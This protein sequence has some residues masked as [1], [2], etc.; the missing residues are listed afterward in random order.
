MAGRFKVCLLHKNFMKYRLTI[1]NLLSGLL[2]I[3]TVIYTISNYSE[4][5]MGLMLMITFIIIAVAGLFV[6]FLLQALTR[7]LKPKKRL[8]V[9][10]V[11]VLLIVGIIIIVFISNLA[12]DIKI[13]NVPDDYTGAIGIAYNVPNVPKLS[14]NGFKID[15]PANGIIL[16]S[17]EIE[18]S[19]D[20]SEI[21]FLR[22]NG[23]GILPSTAYFKKDG[24][25]EVMIG[26]W[27]GS[28]S[29]EVIY[30]CNGTEVII[31]V[32]MLGKQ[33]EEEKAILKLSEIKEK[34]GEYCN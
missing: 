16:T 10:N 9:R 23:S 15:F 33:S 34:L 17:S 22:K 21:S 28:F 18:E 19:N 30:N 7:N 32:V 4:L 3:G 5:D 8:F 20:L 11:P 26:A 1:L 6:D 14:A 12:H 29:E 25:D 2:L 31:K 24:S 13:R 27:K